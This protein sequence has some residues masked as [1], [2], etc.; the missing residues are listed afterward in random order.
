MIESLRR[1][2]YTALSLVLASHTLHVHFMGQGKVGV[3][4]WLVKAYV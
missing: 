2:S 3:S 1:F 4:N